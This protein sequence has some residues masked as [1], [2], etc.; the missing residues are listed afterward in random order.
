M[1]KRLEILLEKY[2]EGN[3][4]LEEERELKDLLKTAEGY[5]MEKSFFSGLGLIADKEEKP[6]QNV[7][8]SN[9]WWR[10]TWFPVAASFLLF[11]IL[12]MSLYQYQVRKEQREAYMQVM[13]ALEMIQ[14][15]MQKGTENLQ[16]LEEFQH[17]NKPNE[18]F[19]IETR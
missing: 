7:P 3:T 13:Q 6:F 11:A 10:N 1:K 14:I 8:I 9:P 16:V 15:N 17:L 12:G 18:I 5:D 2:W 19:E 4:S